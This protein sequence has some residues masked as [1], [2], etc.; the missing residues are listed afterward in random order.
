VMLIKNLC[1]GVD[2]VTS[3]KAIE[4]M[5]TKKIIILDDIDSFPFPIE[6]KEEGWKIK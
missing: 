4:E 2:P 6:E 3:Q 5:R 1:R